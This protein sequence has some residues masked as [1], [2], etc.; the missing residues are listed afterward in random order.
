MEVALE[1]FIGA[2]TVR[3]AR[4]ALRVTDMRGAT[5]CRG[6][7]SYRAT[8]GAEFVVGRR[9]G[10]SSI[11]ALRGAWWC[12]PDSLGSRSWQRPRPPRPPFPGSAAPFCSDEA[13]FGLGGRSSAKKRR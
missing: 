1:G 13:L 10:V 12:R 2:T 11:M 4:R 6:R 7:P 3:G 9:C 5:G 8:E